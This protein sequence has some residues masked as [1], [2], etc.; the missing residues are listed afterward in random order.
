MASSGIKCFFAI[1]QF[2]NGEELVLDQCIFVQF[3]IPPFQVESYNS[4]KWFSMSKHYYYNVLHTF[5][6]N[7][8]FGNKIALLCKFKKKLNTTF[9]KGISFF[10]RCSYIERKRE[11][12]F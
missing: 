12:G 10:R 8:D 3:V 7:D 6:V 11:K 4:H 2:L 5:P 1:K 9:V